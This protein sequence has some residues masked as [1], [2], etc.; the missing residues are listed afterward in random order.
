MQSAGYW[1]AVAGAAG[2]CGCLCLAARRWPGPWAV[3][4]ARLIGVV[5]IAD[6]VTFMSAPV[7]TGAWLLR[8]SLP[9]SL[10]DVALVVAAGAC[11]TRNALLVELTYFWGLTGTLQAVVTPDLSSAFPHLQFFE[12]V[13]GHLAIVVAALY[14]VIGLN[15]APRRRAVPRVLAVTAGYTVMVGLFDAATGAD[16]M[17]LAA[18]PRHWSLLNLLGPW[19]WYVPSAAAVATVL[20][21]VLNAPFVRAQ[22]LGG[23]T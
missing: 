1:L 14:L 11:W 22:R 13:V 5:L 4:A 16:Y 21:V 17:F 19:P 9:L 15:L 20:L 18:R 6:A 7:V 10:C 23:T 8:E 3:T 2:L 12:Y